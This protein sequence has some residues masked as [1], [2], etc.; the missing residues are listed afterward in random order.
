[1]TGDAS[2]ARISE[3]LSQDRDLREA[4]LETLASRSRGLAVSRRRQPPVHL[5]PPAN[6]ISAHYMLGVEPAERDRDGR[7]ASDSRS[8]R[9]S[10]RAGPRAAPGAVHRAARPNTW[11]RDVLM[12]RVLRSP[13]AEH[14][15]ADAAV[16][17][18]VTAMPAP[19]KV[20][21]IL[22][23]EIDPESM[24]K[25]LDLAIG[26]AVFDRYGK[27]VLPAGRSGRSIRRTP[28]SPIRY[29]LTVAVDPGTY[30]VRLAADRSGGQERQRRARS[31]R[32]PHGGT[33]SSRWAI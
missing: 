13:A 20:K 23:A 30:R 11:S 14:R 8:G 19:N 15:A 29:E 6:E 1:M 21:L 31:R 27:A 12:G 10:E 9:P 7:A 26:F 28:I 32:V 16:Q 33:R 18:Y 17:L 5:R 24:E 3:T 25:E 22:A 4:G 2:Q